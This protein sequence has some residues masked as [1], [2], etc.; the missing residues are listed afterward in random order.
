VTL[1][2]TETKPMNKTNVGANLGEPGLGIA[3]NISRR[4]NVHKANIFIGKYKN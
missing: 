1:G 2:Q 4:E 3:D